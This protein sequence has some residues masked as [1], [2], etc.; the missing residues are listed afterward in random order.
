MITNNLLH[1]LIS[2]LAQVYTSSQVLCTATFP[3][4]D[5]RAFHQQEVCDV[6]VQPEVITPVRLLTSFRSRF[7]EDTDCETT[8]KPHKCSFFWLYIDVTSG[9]HFLLVERMPIPKGEAIP[10][11]LAVYTGAESGH[12]NK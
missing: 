2:V 8:R 1:S 5:W 6:N 9:F 3:S 4:W 10:A 7:P 12:R 11:R